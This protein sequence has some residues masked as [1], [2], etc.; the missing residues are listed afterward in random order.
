MT[1]GKN[2]LQVSSTRPRSIK[3][4]L[5]RWLV[6]IVL[7][8]VSVSVTQMSSEKVVQANSDAN[9]NQTVTGTLV[10]EANQVGSDCVVQF[11]SGS[12][13]WT[14]PAGISV[15]SKLLVV[16]GGG[17]GGQAKGSNASSGQGKHGG[18]GGGG[19]GV[20]PKNNFSVIGEFLVTV[21]AGGPSTDSIGGTGARGETSV[22]GS[23]QAGGGGGGG[24]VEG[25]ISGNNSQCP[26][27][28]DRDQ[29]MVGG[30]PNGAGGGGAGSG[31]KKCGGTG[32]TGYWGNSGTGTGNGGGGGG[33]GGPRNQDQAKLRPGEAGVT[34][35]ITGEAI[36]YAAGAAGA[37]LGQTTNVT[38]TTPGGGGAG[39][40][41]FIEGLKAHNGNPGIVVIR[42]ALPGPDIYAPTA[43]VTTATVGSTQN[44]VARSTEVGTVFLVKSTN[45]T[46]TTVNQILGFTANTRTTGTAVATADSDTNVPAAMLTSGEYK[47][48]AADIAGNLSVAS[49]NTVTIDAVSPA[50]GMGRFTPVTSSTSRIAVQ[51][52][53]TGTA[54]LVS[55][56][57]TVTNEESITSA[58]DADFNSVAIT[59]PDTLT[60]LATTGLNAGTYRLYAVDAV[61]N[62]SFPFGTTVT[63]GTDS[64]APVLTAITPIPG[65]T[66]AGIAS[67][68]ILRF[69]EPVAKGNDVAKTISLVRSVVPTIT[70]GSLTGNVATLTFSSN[71]GFV[72]GDKI[73][74]TGCSNTVYNVNATAIT[75]V[76]GT[77]ITFAKTN[78]DIA[79]AALTGCAYTATKTDGANLITSSEVIGSNSANLAID[80]FP[81]DNRAILNPDGQM[82]F[83][84]AYHV[85]ISAGA[86]VDQAAT[87]NPFAA[88]SSPTFWSFTTGTDTVAPTLNGATSDPPNG[89]ATF[90]PSRNIILRFSEPVVDIANKFIKLCTGA[91]NCATPV[92]TFTLQT[93]TASDGL[94]TVSEN[95]VTLNPTADLLFSTTYFVLIEEGAFTDGTGNQFAGMATCAAHPCTYEFA[96]AAAPVAGAPPPTPGKAP[97]SCGSPPAP[98][99]N[100][101]RGINFGPGN[102][103][104]NPN[105]LAGSDMANLRPDNFV[106]FR[107]ADARLLGAGALQ[108]F[109]P[110]QF[111][112]LPPTAMAGFDRG[113]ISNLNPAAMAGMSKDQ[114]AALP[115]SAMGGFN[116]NQMAALP[117]SAMAGF[118]PT[119]MAALPPSAMGGFNA[120]QMGQLS[121]AAMTG[122]KLDQ[123]KVLPASAITGMQEGQFAALP[124]QAMIGFK[125]AQFAALP[126]DAISGM[127]R[128]QF[129]VIPAKAMA[130]FT[131]TQMD[132]MPVGALAVISP[133]Q[134]KALTP[135]V[136]ASM[137]PEQRSAL[138]RQALN[139]AANAAPANTGDSAALARVLT[140]WN[141][142]KVPAT[143]FANFKPADAAK[144]SPQVFSSLN[145][146]QF[147]AMPAAAFTGMKPNQVGALP[148]DV[149]ATL[150]PTQL[151]S[152]PAAAL[153]SLNTEQ[154]SAMP[155]AA[156]TGMKPTQVGA[157]PAALISNMSSQQVGALPARAMAGLKAEQVSALPPEAMATMKPAQVG[158]LKPAA[159]AS[160][161]ADQVGALPAAAF[162]AMKPTQVGAMPAA[163]MATMSPQQVGALPARA[164]AGLKAEQVSAL[165]PEAIA[166]MKPKQVAK[167]KPATAAGFSNEKLAALTPAQTRKL[168]PAFVNALTPEQKAALNS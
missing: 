90:T 95:T 128:N 60:S 139:P 166:T 15:L 80:A 165:P 132:A 105:A 55:T 159:V 13:T 110:S 28:A 69:N 123:L 4:N 32:A 154:F 47:V 24:G 161:S 63:I 131:P 158:A 88:I 126:P 100:V 5:Y 43:S 58:A 68:L 107:P 99:C 18:G 34:N 141:V 112:A 20:T 119:R 146:E 127:Q 160:L 16:G 62:L 140:G 94:V 78:A 118:D 74:T 156:F 65:E 142:D 106:G 56:T 77:S 82:L 149:L 48:Y 12:G 109:Q 121:P 89:M 75:G 144:L 76:T 122:M 104:S 53:E 85:L 17:G 152:M 9:C 168:K 36:I 1:V 19:G 64:A 35:T 81:N 138:P 30:S 40:A 79:S 148:P 117:P 73:T 45:A 91:V 134:F 108:N 8:L 86:I 42:Y 57:V 125:P 155:P 37:S 136:I 113:Q 39:S 97:V 26:G 2:L 111:G 114:M 93:S 147:K 25:N 150:K 167:L 96:T 145:P 66:Q 44:A 102:V 103:I 130:A 153:G 61:D 71:P 120:S 33:L 115:A 29:A 21:G 83:G 22:F 50:V 51:S 49:T 67:N 143:A 31:I 14:P 129:R 162:G 92:Q 133:S 164:M 52:S 3:A 27:M 54:Y 98:P 38:N 163:L 46:P 7:I 101:R 11:T 135:A 59:A 87:P 41:N 84:V 137:S 151:A 6:S 157:M 72:V 70:N 124:P 23:E 116:A 10:Y